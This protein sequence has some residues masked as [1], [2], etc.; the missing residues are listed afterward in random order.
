MCP[1]PGPLRLPSCPQKLE[2]NRGQKGGDGG[3]QGAF[4]ACVSCSLFPVIPPHVV[5]AF[6]EPG[7]E[8]GH[9][10]NQAKMMRR[11]GSGTDQEGTLDPGEDPGELPTEGPGECGP[12]WRE[13]EAQLLPEDG[14]TESATI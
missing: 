13:R 1:A 11:K 10:D 14:Q 2:Q 12:E 7:L 6:H 5:C 4:S 9:C 8:R 3:D